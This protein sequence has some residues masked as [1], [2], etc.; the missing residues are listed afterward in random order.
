[1]FGTVDTN[2]SGYQT[3]ISVYFLFYQ[4][5]TTFLIRYIRIQSHSIFGGISCR[6]SRNSAGF[7]Q[8]ILG[9]S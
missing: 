6:H 9:F 8:S 4:D 3:Y 5:V 7:P 1:M 2:L